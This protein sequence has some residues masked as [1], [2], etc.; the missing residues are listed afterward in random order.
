MVVGIQG[1][2]VWPKRCN[3]KGENANTTFSHPP[4]GV[5]ALGNGFPLFL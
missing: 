3:A 1:N 2:R 4:R 5:R